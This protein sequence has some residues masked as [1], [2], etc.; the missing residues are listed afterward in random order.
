MLNEH[1][2]LTEKKICTYNTVLQ[3]TKFLIMEYLSQYRDKQGSTLSRGKMGFFLF[4]TALR[5]VLGPTLN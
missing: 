3:F 4:A 1:R 2:F 5:L